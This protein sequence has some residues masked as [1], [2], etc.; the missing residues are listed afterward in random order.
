M[1]KRN[2]IP[3]IL[4]IA[5]LIVGTIAG[6]FLLNSRQIFR[7]GASGDAAPKDVRVSNIDNTGFTVNWV[8]DKKVSGYILWGMAEGSVTNIQNDGA[9]DTKSFTHSVVVS[10]RYPDKTYYY[11]I[12]SDGYTFDNNALPWQTGTAPSI[13]V[14]RSQGLISGSVLTA[15]G[16]PVEAAIVYMNVGGYLAS[17]VTSS[18]GNFVFQLGSVRSQDLGSYQNI[19]PSQSLIE[20]SV[21]AGPGGVA[22]AQ[23]YSQS[24]NPAPPIVLGQTQDFRNLPPITNG[25]SPDAN[26]NLPEDATHESKFNVPT[27]LTAPAA[28]TVILENIDN[29]EIVS[30]TKPE[31]M[32]KG[33]EGTVIS[34]TVESENPISEEISVPKDGS[35]NWSPPTDLAPGNHKITLS[36]KDASGITRSLTRSF[37]VQAAEIPAF[38]AT[39]S[40]GLATPTGSP[41][42]TPTGT[43]KATATPKVTASASAEPIPVTG[44]LTPTFALSIMGIAVMIFS[45]F[46][47]KIAE[48]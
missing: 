23:L 24:G 34:I 39:P 17:T 31:F 25:G 29:G 41:S 12:N 6:A 33:P 21:Q 5:F 27:D 38:E 44:S 4:G 19:N 46:I 42:G 30:S 3:T 48:N 15:T 22:S 43:P 32:G 2:N 40:Q 13:G 9:G 18:T 1:K 11:K 28:T 10:G 20:I 36:W 47:W 7:L 37:I 45:F 8:T 14:G 35:W 16:T 26:L